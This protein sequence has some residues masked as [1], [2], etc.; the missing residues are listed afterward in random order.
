MRYAGFW[1]R[2]IAACLDIVILIVL[3]LPTYLLDDVLAT[4]VQLIAAFVYETILTSTRK[5]ATW[6]K[7]LVGIRV[8]NLD[9]SP[10]SYG[11]SVGRY[12]A[13][14]LSSI[15]L[16]IGYIMIAF[17]DRKQGLHDRLADTVVLL[18]KNDSVSEVHSSPMPA[19]M[20]AG[21]LKP[22]ATRGWVMAGFDSSGH[23]TRFRFDNL[24]V[25]LQQNE[26]LKIGRNDRE[27]H[28]VVSDGSVSRV[29]ARLTVANDQLY[30]EDLGSKNGTFIGGTRID[31]HSKTRLFGDQE[32]RLGDVTF[33][34]G[35]E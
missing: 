33:S 1:I 23:V 15:T 35:R 24:D 6:G 14:W 17:T 4:F 12:F 10:I 28:F 32:L 19:D 26:G 29:H 3:L 11:K 5:Q 27:N 16:L 13:K 20:L 22:K 7:Q 8:S 31:V 30:V 18:E 25:R 21:A 9:G 2:A 34:I